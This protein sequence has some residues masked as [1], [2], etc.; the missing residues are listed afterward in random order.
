MAEHQ[1]RTS[2]KSPMLTGMFRDRDSAEKAY[3]CLTSRGYT[4][5]DVTLLMSDRGSP[6]GRRRWRG[7]RRFARGPHRFRHP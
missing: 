5:D 4:K 1:I 6:D 7:G 2:S 3:T